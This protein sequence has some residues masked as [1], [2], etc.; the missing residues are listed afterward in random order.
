MA[1][2]H[3]W[4]RL[5]RRRLQMDSFM[6]SLTWYRREASLS[7]V[8]LNRV[9]AKRVSAQTYVIGPRLHVGG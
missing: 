6:V 8:R 7:N 9:S 5:L 1:L 2:I 3:L 4:A